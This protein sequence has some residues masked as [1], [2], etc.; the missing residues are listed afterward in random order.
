MHFWFPSPTDDKG[1]LGLRA[2]LIVP[3]RAAS[4]VDGAFGGAQERRLRLALAGGPFPG[5]K[6][7][8]HRWE[9]PVQRSLAGS[10]AERE[11]EKKKK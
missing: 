5:R 7:G 3:G 10:T 11:R 6:A 9:E 4:G 1:F 2:V 8:A